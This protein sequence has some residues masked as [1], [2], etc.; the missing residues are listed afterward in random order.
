MSLL[1]R[2]DN[3]AIDVKATNNNNS[4]FTMMPLVL[5]ADPEADILDMELESHP[6]C[7]NDYLVVYTG[8]CGA[9]RPA[10]LCGWSLPHPVLSQGG[11]L[12]VMFRS[13]SMMSLRGFNATVEHAGK[14]VVC[15]CGFSSD[16]LLLLLCV[17][18]VC[19]ISGGG[20]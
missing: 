9:A 13:D 17:L 19:F 12:C 3:S 11:Q 2:A 10:R 18:F 4:N 8:R 7:Y 5:L 6:A 16:L 15:C 20:K 1:K 14:S